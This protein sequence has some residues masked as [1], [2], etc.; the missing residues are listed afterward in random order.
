MNRYR[1]IAQVVLEAS[2]PLAI[3]TGRKSLMT[4]APVIKDMNGLPYIPAT[5]LTGVIRHLCKEEFTD[6]VFGFQKQ[7]KTQGSRI[8]FTD[9]I[10]IGKDGKPVEGILENPDDE[11]YQHFKHLPIRHH[12]RISDKGCVEKYGKFDNEVVYKGTRFCFR[13]E[14]CA[15]E[16]IYYNYFLQILQKLWNEGFRL[17][18][19][20]HNGLGEMEVVDCQT[21]SLDL[22]KEEDLPTYLNLSSSLQETPNCL[23][24]YKKNSSH[25]DEYAT[26]H[27]TLK[28]DNFFL[29]GAACGDEEADM[30]P[31]TE[32]VIEWNQEKPSFK[33]EKEEQVLIPATSVK[34]ALSHRTAFYYN[35]KKER[36]AEEYEAKEA[37]E[38]VTALFGSN[39][40]DGKMTAGKVYFSDIFLAPKEQKILNHVAIDDFTGGAINGALFSEKVEY[41]PQESFTLVISVQ[42]ETFLDK[43]VKEAFEQALSDLCNGMLPLGGGVNRGNGCFNGTCKELK[44]KQL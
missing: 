20:T 25:D 13:M 43:D 6:D 42:K 11:F 21:A 29:F 14:M 12:T 30:K 3:G 34:G 22:S 1:Y 44:N 15:D 19:N 26:Y 24:P 2:T 18:G 8:S 35:L 36:F 39:E 41:R 31:V 10:M 17:G 40:D 27:V 23:K 5:A 16:E 4:D 37:N 28:P 32:T 7:N 33:E 38:A 9:G